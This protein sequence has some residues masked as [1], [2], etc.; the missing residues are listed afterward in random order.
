MQPMRSRSGRPGAVLL[1]VLLFAC[2][3]VEDF[4][5]RM[6]GATPHDDYVEALRSAG[7]LDAALGRDWTESARRALQEPL[8][9]DLPV[10]ETGYF[11]AG[12]PAAV[13]LR[14]QISRGQRVI[15]E[16]DLVPDSTALLFVDVFRASA[17]T[18]AEP[19]HVAAADSGARVLELEPSRTADYIIRVQPELLRGGRY[20]VRVHTQP[21]LTFPVHGAGERAIGSR[22]G[23]PRDG[24]AREHHGIDIFAPR[25]TPVLASA[26]GVVNRVR[27]TPR[28]GRVVW[29]RDEARGQSL[30]YAH[31]DTQLVSD[32][33]RVAAGDTIG[34]VGNTGNAAATPPHLH[35]GI[36][37]R[38]E[39]PVDPWDF[40]RRPPTDPPRLAADTALLGTWTRVRAAAT[41]RA[42]LGDS[43]RIAASTAVRV[44]GAS[45]S[46]FRV[47]MPDGSAGWLDGSALSGT[48]LASVTRDVP[49]VLRDAPAHQAA[50]IIAVEPGT[51][52]DVVGRF[53]G[54][55]LL[56]DGALTG[57]SDCV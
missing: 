15:I 37:R 52:M 51:R 17:D 28:G 38:G 9:A 2:G 40:V 33:E 32:G 55:A 21:T 34:T 39:G 24:G 42:P 27:E 45:G 35:F 36:Y 6:R 50:E 30:Y 7:L 20:R 49:C 3:P 44:R 13:S 10:E 18:A 5:D 46:S 23:A 19:V 43:V 8:P 31:L 12:R 16:T 11:D 54:Y 56:R 26:A 29:L 57:W 1:F 14:V 41:L 22:F 25:G 47:E 48:P 53:G 4:R